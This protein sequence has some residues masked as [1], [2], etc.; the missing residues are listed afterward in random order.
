MLGRVD[1]SLEQLE[2]TT[3]T[4]DSIVGKIDRGEGTVGLLINDPR[5]YH[6]MD[7][8]VNSMNQLLVDLKENPVRYM[9]ALRLVDLF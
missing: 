2:S 8:T 9:R 3:T 5:L 1:R 6:R 7:S 4:L